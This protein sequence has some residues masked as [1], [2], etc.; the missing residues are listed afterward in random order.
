MLMLTL[1]WL[2]RRVETDSPTYSWMN[3]KFFIAKIDSSNLPVVSF[4]IYEETS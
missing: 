3:G 1:V 4:T 2:F